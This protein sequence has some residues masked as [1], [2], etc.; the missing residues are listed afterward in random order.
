MFVMTLAMRLASVDT[1]EMD[2]VTG[3]PEDRSAI[4]E[5]DSVEVTYPDPRVYFAAERTLLAWIRT[6]VALIAF[7]FVVAKVGFEPGLSNSVV[8]G[9]STG[10]PASALLGALLVV[11]GLILLVVSLLR[12]RRF[13][14]AMEAN[15]FRAVF[16]MRLPVLLVAMLCVGGGWL[17]YLLL[18]RQGL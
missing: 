6:G 18:T 2:S 1:R 16:N 13:I 8:Q 14:L 5:E 10:L 9:A 4:A 7:G 17:L 11:M 15:R 3:K 12:H